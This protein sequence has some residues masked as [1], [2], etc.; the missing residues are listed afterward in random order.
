MADENDLADWERELLRPINPEAQG[1]H[2]LMQ[3]TGIHLPTNLTFVESEE[4]Y[5]VY[6]AADGGTVYLAHG[7]GQ[8]LVWFEEL[9][10]PDLW[11]EYVSEL[12]LRDLRERQSGNRWTSIHERFLDRLRG[13][14]IDP[15][16]VDAVKFCADCRGADHEDDLV[17]TNSSHADVCESC[18]DEYHT[19]QDCDDR[20]RQT[21]TTLSDTQ[22]CEGCIQEHWSWCDDCEGYYPDDDSAEHNHHDDD[23]NG[24]SCGCESPATSFKV[25][26]DGE[27]LLEN[28]TRVTVTLPAG[29]ISDEGINEI[30]T[31]LRQVANQVPR[32]VDPNATTN[33]NCCSPVYERSQEFSDLWNLS[34]VVGEL[35]EK[36]QTKEGNY[37]KRLSRMAYK[38][39]GLK[40]KP[41][42][43]SKVGCIASDHSTAVDFALEVTR[44][45]NMSPD[46]FAHED[47]CWWQSYY[48]SRC[49][50]KSNGG[51]GIRTF[52]T[53]AGY[54]SDYTYVSG[55]AWVMPLKQVEH[56]GSKY[57]T[58]TFET[59]QPDAFVVFNGYGDLNGYAAARIL[60]HMAGMTYRKIGFDAAP[61]YVNNCSG[62]LV[63][64]EEIASRYTDGHLNLDVDQHSS[65][66]RDEI[67]NPTLFDNEKVL[68]S[69]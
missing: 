35:G 45:L 3:T 50:L 60:S 51:F 59:R 31:Y 56:Y 13:L 48:S 65:L 47:S 17:P 28:D 10:L 7:T 52:T 42:V 2:P 54:T 46:E 69:A 21:T 37:T 49:T 32:V 18:I 55:R 12:T 9:D 64:P 22:A 5:S 63:A 6:R 26:N 25:R 57:L 43:V 41:E 16:E 29:V 4:A 67:A 36:W 68:A 66:Y 23:D 44:E 38:R 8:Q 40:L 15:D 53:S 24:D 1:G 62:Y 33:C 11:E 27:P 61:M 14:V 30:V 20:F 19:C 58:P 39:F 34:H